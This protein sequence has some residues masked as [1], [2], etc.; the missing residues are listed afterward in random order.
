MTTIGEP[1]TPL[2]A[3]DMVPL[4]KGMR[5]A[6]D[7]GLKVGGGGEDRRACNTQHNASP[8]GGENRRQR[9]SQGRTA[10]TKTAGGPATL[11]VARA[12]TLPSKGM[13]AADDA[14]PLPEGVRAADNVG[15]KGNSGGN[16]G[17]RACNAQPSASPG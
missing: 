15:L 3:R 9:R 14:A 2:A 10:S 5:A 12:T 4:P 1:A 11:P 6:N 17:M 7:V 8:E 13:R 16:N